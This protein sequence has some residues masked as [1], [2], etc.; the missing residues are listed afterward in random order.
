MEAVR[1]FETPVDLY[2]IIWRYI[3]EN[4]ALHMVYLPYIYRALIYTLEY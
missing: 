2:W 4:G 3:P 1:S